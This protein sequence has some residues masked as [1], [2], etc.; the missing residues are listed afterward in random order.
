MFR[1]IREIKELLVAVLNMIAE[2]R[3]VQKELHVLLQDI[4]EKRTKI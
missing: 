1:L 4:K 2:A 3:D